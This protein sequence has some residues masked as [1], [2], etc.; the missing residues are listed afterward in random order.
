MK[1][2]QVLSIDAW[3]SNCGWYWNQWFSAGTIDL[4]TLDNT[5][6]ILAAMRDQGYLSDNSKGKVSIDDD[7]HNLVICD[8]NTQEP[9]F[10]IEYGDIL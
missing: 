8:R 6:K 2:Y 4:E 3:R 9:I 7:Q 5:R 1:T 10:A